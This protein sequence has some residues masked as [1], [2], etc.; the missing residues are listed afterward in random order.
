LQPPWPGIPLSW[1]LTSLKIVSVENR[2]SRGQTL[3]EMFSERMMDGCAIMPCGSFE[4]I[5]NVVDR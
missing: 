1:E 2:S 4:S 5:A 3:L